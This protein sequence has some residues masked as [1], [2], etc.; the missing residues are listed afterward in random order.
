[1]ELQESLQ[2]LN[3]LEMLS[4]P[5]LPCSTNQILTQQPHCW[6]TNQLYLIHTTKEKPISFISSRIPLFFPLH[7][8]CVLL[9]F[10][11]RNSNPGLW[12]KKARSHTS[13]TKKPNGKH[14]P[15]MDTYSMHVSPIIVTHLSSLLV[16]LAP[17]AALFWTL[18]REG[19]IRSCSANLIWSKV[20]SYIRSPP[21][22]WWSGR[23]TMPHRVS[24]AAGGRL[25]TSLCHVMWRE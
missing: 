16:V 13:P 21:P 18:K 11:V 4:S 5:C 7:V 23:M 22:L 3:S 9:V 17:S 14:L 12:Q 19:P 2:S 20:K 6:P 8:S 25:L 24:R 10:S 15:E 1:M